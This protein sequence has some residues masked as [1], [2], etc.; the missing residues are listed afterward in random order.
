MI[1][2]W[3]K[4][5]LDECKSESLVMCI[6]EL[7]RLNSSN[8]FQFQIAFP[9]SG[10]SRRQVMQHLQKKVINRFWSFSLF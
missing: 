3:K 4:S 10:K 2:N 5:V 8:T 7:L 6:F 1:F 9:S